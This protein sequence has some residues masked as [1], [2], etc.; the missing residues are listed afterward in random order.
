ARQAGQE[1]GLARAGR[2][3]DRDQLARLETE[4]DAPQ[5]ERLVIA[6]V[7]EPVQA[8]CAEH[9][10][11]ADHRTES[12]TILHG[13]TLSAPLGPESVSTASLPCLKKTYRSTASVPAF[14]VTGSDGA[15]A[16]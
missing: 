16:R 9:R 6:R 5:G 2:A 7:E 10:G 11:H 3:G 13:S 12:V 4:R 14:P 1:R 15:F 8:A